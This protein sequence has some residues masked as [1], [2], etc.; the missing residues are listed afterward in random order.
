MFSLTLFIIAV[1]SGETL[2][3]LGG[4]NMLFPSLGDI[5]ES[6]GEVTTRFV[7]YNVN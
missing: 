2:R 7:R 5:R 6:V 4:V 1:V 3:V